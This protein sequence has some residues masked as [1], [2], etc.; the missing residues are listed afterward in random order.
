MLPKYRNGSLT[1]KE[2][3]EALER[4]IQEIN[5]Q[6]AAKHAQRKMLMDHI[7]WFKTP[8]KTTQ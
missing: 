1:P 8:R 7:A 2:M 6:I 5:E 4:K 3:I